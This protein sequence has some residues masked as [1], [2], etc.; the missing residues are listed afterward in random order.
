MNHTLRSWCLR[1]VVLVLLDPE[2]EPDLVIQ[3]HGHV[4][5]TLSHRLLVVSQSTSDRIQL[6]PDENQQYVQ[7]L[8]L[9]DEHTLGYV[10][11]VLGFGPMGG[12]I[13]E[14]LSDRVRGLAR[15]ARAD[16]PFHFFT[17]G[18]ASHHQGPLV[19]WLVPL[20]HLSA[21]LLCCDFGLLSALCSIKDLQNFV[22]NSVQPLYKTGDRMVEK[23]FREECK[24]LAWCT[25]SCDAGPAPS[26]SQQILLSL[27]EAP[28]LPSRHHD[29]PVNGHSEGL[30][31]YSEIDEFVADNFP[32]RAYTKDLDGWEYQIP[33]KWRLLRYVTCCDKQGRL[34]FHHP[35]G[36][37]ESLAWQHEVRV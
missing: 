34:L 24:S 20:G 27:F 28:S 21:E 3:I 6:F 19:N 16:T 32:S 10:H 37:E 1:P 4:C 11:M 9:R 8:R 29:T 5:S 25:R 14:F 30:Q 2:L 13:H 36:S 31:R 15:A 23:R 26:A 33:S 12:H 18:A 22:T 17:I 35:N 7:D